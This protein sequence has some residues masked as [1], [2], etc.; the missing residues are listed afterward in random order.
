MKLRKKKQKK[1]E[2]KMRKK[3]GTSLFIHEE[4]KLHKSG[5]FFWQTEIIFHSFYLSLIHKIKR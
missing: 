5:Q 3:K 2:E 4:M 1:R